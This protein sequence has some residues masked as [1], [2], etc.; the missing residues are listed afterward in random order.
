MRHYQSNDPFKRKGWSQK[1]IKVLS[2]AYKQYPYQIPQWLVDK[3]G[4]AGCHSKASRCGFAKGIRHPGIDTSHWSES[5]KGY[6][7]GFL[8]GEGSIVFYEDRKKPNPAILLANTH[9]GVLEYLQEKLTVGSLTITVREKKNP[10]W[11]TLYQ[12]HI[13]GAKQVYDILKA[14]ESYLIIKREKA[15]KAIRLLKEK[16]QFN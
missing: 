10:K 9:K 15:L 8:D 1:D 14:I 2:Q 6:L 13:H 4:Q 12:L 3:H 16:Y 5:L 7:A 11:K